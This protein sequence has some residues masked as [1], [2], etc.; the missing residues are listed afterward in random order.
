[1]VN[2]DGWQKTRKHNIWSF[3]QESIKNRELN[4]SGKEQMNLSE[5]AIS[6]YQLDY[7]RKCYKI[8]LTDMIYLKKHSMF[9]NVKQRCHWYLEKK[10]WWYELVVCDTDTDPDMRKGKLLYVNKYRNGMDVEDVQWHREILTL[11][12]QYWI[13]SLLWKLY[14]NIIEENPSR[15]MANPYSD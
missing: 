11:L 7:S 13:A 2:I 14:Y 10:I 1:V 4:I 6:G 5:R 12:E 8:S 3:I 15:H 9:R